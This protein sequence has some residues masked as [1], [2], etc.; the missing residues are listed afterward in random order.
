M[1]WS[2]GHY[3]IYSQRPLSSTHTAQ[4]VQNDMQWRLDSGQK[5]QWYTFF[6]RVQPKSHSREVTVHCAEE[7]ERTRMSHVLPLFGGRSTQQGTFAFSQVQ[8]CS[9]PS[10]GSWN[11]MSTRIFCLYRLQI[12][13]EIFTISHDHDRKLMSVSTKRKWKEIIEGGERMRRAKVFNIYRLHRAWSSSDVPL[14]RRS[15]PNAN[16]PFVSLSWHRTH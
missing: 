13:A 9:H 1:Y 15:R 8:C 11:F 2:L 12:C 6:N 10:E 3:I 16:E 7:N 5:I 14:C 4:T